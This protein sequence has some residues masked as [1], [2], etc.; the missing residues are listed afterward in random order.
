M[1]FTVLG[2]N[3]TERVLIQFCRSALVM[4]SIIIGPILDRCVLAICSYVLIVV[5]ESTFS[6]SCIYFCTASET[7][8]FARE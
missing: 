3:L 5:G 6:F 4:V 1:F 7:V 2:D 8:R